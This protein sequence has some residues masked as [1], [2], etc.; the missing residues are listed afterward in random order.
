MS[1]NGQTI[2]TDNQDS[3]DDEPRKIEHKMEKKGYYA[4]DITVLSDYQDSKPAPQS[5][6]RALVNSVTVFGS[7]MGGA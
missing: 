3:P 7:E 5:K 2:A 1:L 4:L 6:A